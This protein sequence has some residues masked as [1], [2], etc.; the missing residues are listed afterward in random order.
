MSTLSVIVVQT[1]LVLLG[2]LFCKKFFL[3][4]LKKRQPICI[5]GKIRIFSGDVIGGWGRMGRRWTFRGDVIGR[6]WRMEKGGCILK[7]EEL[8]EASIVHGF[9]RKK[10]FHEKFD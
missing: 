8:L 9:A 5:Y 6:G 7:K 10:V 3:C 2:I 4:L 1:T